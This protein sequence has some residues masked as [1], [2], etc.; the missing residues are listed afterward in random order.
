MKENNKLVA[1]FMGGEIEDKRMKDFTFIFNNFYYT[2]Y[3]LEP[4]FYGGQGYLDINEKCNYCDLSDMKFHKSWDWL[5][6]VVE[7][8]EDYDIIASFQI[9]HPTIFIWSSSENSTFEDIEVNTFGKT[10]IEAVY[11]AVIEF[12]KWYNKNV[13]EDDDLDTKQCT[14]L[15][16]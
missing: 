6:P 9:E 14:K 3:T 5:M 1:E 11:T 8:I 10:K 12:I 15:K 2:S 16:K 13:K 7:K 4:C